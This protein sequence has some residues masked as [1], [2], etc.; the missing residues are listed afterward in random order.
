MVFP[1]LILNEVYAWGHDH[2]E[3]FGGPNPGAAAIAD[4]ATA[5]TGLEIDYFMLVDLT[6]FADVVDAF[7]GVEMVVPSPIDGPLYDTATGGYE[8]IH[9]PAGSQRLDGATALAYARSRHTTS[10]YDRMG[11]QRCILT[12]L[13]GQAD[14]VSLLTG[15]PDLLAAVERNISTDIPLALV[16]DLVRLAGSVRASEIRV[17]GFGPEW[18]KGRNSAGYTIPD[19]DRIQRAVQ[20]A[21]ENPASTVQAATA[22]DACR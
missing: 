3:A 9:I 17:L 1:G 11:R 10:D 18:G 21:I 15:L 7:G 12:A 2:P 4:V 19:V 22:G 14:P 6:G 16:P 13:V 20:D 8:M 5:L